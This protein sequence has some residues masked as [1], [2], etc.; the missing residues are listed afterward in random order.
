MEK[1]TS[2]SPFAPSSLRMPSRDDDQLTSRSSGEVTP[3]STDPS[4]VTFVPTSAEK[5]GAGAR[6]TAVGLELFALTLVSSQLNR[7]RARM[8]RGATR[9]IG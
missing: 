1:V 5:S 9:F 2:P 6:M 8:S 3:S 7:R 4:N